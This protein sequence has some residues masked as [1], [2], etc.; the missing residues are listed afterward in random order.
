MFGRWFD[1]EVADL[2]NIFF[3]RAMVTDERICPRNT[4]ADDQQRSVRQKGR[5]SKAVTAQVFRRQSIPM[6]SSHPVH[7]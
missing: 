6:H 1:N 2:T 5:S 3:P 7:H 4:A